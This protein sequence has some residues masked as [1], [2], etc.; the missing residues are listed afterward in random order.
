M[1]INFGFNRDSYREDVNFTDYYWFKE[2]FNKEELTRI[3]EMTKKLNLKTL[4]QAKMKHLKHQIIEN[5]E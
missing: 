1:R 5:Q 3:E 4:Q 2:A